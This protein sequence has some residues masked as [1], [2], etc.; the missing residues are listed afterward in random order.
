MTAYLSAAT[1]RTSTRLLLFNTA[2]NA[3]VDLPIRSMDQHL[4]Q[5]ATIRARLVV[6][7]VVD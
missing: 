4:L 6:E 2:K 3:F 5:N 7:I 1:T